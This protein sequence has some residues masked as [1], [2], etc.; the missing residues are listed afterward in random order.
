MQHQTSNG[1]TI[2]AQTISVGI[3]APEHFV[4][5]DGVHDE[6]VIHPT[7]EFSATVDMTI[8]GK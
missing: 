3:S 7:P 4:A 5:G 1:Q 2:N 6:V 8:S